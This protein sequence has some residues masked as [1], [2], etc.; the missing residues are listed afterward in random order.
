M[1]ETQFRFDM[2]QHTKNILAVSADLSGV[3]QAEFLRRAIV[4]HGVDIMNGQT[5]EFLRGEN[6]S[7]ESASE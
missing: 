5:P 4:F 7:N 1:E 6:G 2:D 3:S